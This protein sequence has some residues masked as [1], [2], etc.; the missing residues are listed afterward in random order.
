MFHGNGMVISNGFFCRKLC[1]LNFS[2]LSSII[3]QSFKGAYKFNLI[4]PNT[5]NLLVLGALR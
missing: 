4:S 5:E 2:Q 3:A 1:L